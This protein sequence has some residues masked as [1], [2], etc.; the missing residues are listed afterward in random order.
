MLFHNLD[1][2]K[3]S[4]PSILLLYTGTVI[5]RDLLNLY[6][7]YYY[8]LSFRT[9]LKIAHIYRIPRIDFIDHTPCKM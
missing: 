3:L 7:K 8:I 6:Q 1:V 5:V 2:I 4:C 9:A